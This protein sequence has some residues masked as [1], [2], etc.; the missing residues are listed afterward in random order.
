MAIY[1]TLF[2][3]YQV[4]A[5]TILKNKEHSRTDRQELDEPEL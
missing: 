5:K 4:A 3:G 2:L 1:A